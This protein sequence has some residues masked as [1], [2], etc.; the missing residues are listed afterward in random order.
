MHR[1]NAILLVSPCDLQGRKA[2]CKRPRDGHVCNVY[3]DPCVLWTRA[4]IEYQ[5][6]FNLLFLTFLSLSIFLNFTLSR[7]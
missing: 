5:T 4:T 2:K 3:S 6:E 1:T 7:L